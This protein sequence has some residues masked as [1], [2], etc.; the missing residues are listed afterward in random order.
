MYQGGAALDVVTALR[1]MREQVIPAMTGLAQPPEDYDIDFVYTAR[2]TSVSKVL[3]C[4]RGFDGYNSSLLLARYQ[5]GE[6]RDTAGG[7]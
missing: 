4:A 7:T 2:E 1:A 6:P 5:K 3:V